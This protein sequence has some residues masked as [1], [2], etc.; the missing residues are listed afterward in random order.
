MPGEQAGHLGPSSTP[1]EQHRC[2]PPF[3]DGRSIADCQSGRATAP[4][5]LFVTVPGSS[6][7][8]PPPFCHSSRN[9]LTSDT[10]FLSL[11]GYAISYMSLP[12]YAPRIN[13]RRF[14]P[15]RPSV[16]VLRRRFPTYRAFL[17]KLPTT[18]LSLLGVGPARYPTTFLSLFALPT[19][20][21]APPFCHL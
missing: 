12:G 20:Q 10:T 9:C 5:H 11:S 15:K 2:R 19:P 3:V 7:S 1:G 8:R 16:R 13:H 6:R 18:F 4:G 21:Q 14:C 17:W